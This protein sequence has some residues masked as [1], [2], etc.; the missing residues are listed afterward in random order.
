[1]KYKT[2]DFLKAI[3]ALNVCFF[4]LCA[5]WSIAFGINPFLSWWPVLGLPMWPFGLLIERIEIKESLDNP[6]LIW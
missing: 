2:S 6:A 3:F 5:C 1:M 4:M